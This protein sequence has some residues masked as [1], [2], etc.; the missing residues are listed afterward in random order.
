MNNAYGN[1]ATLSQA[2]AM[3]GYY[4]AAYFGN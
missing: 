3:Y 1:M 2:A 4:A